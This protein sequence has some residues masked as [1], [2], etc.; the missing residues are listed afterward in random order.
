M[1]LIKKEL[2][3][4]KSITLSFTFNGIAWFIIGI[5]FA[6]DSNITSVI[7]VIALLYIMVNLFKLCTYKRGIR[8]EMSNFNI[9][10]AQAK[11]YM[12]TALLIAIALLSLGFIANIFPNTNPFQKDVILPLHFSILGISFIIVGILFKKYEEE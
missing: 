1:S 4:K 6:I 5:C 11:S 8:D 2:S 7:S 12:I 10:K 3:V 9:L